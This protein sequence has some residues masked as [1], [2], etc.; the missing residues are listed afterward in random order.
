MKTPYEL[1]ISCSTGKDNSWARIIF[2][3]V[4]EHRV[5]QPAVFLN[6]NDYKY[7]YRKYLSSVS[8]PNRAFNALLNALFNAPF[9]TSQMRHSLTL[10]E[11][12][13]T[14]NPLTYATNPLTYQTIASV[15]VAGQW[16]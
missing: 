12:N 10:H 7:E 11:P 4:H 3:G 8:T 15:L 5:T 9:Y 2:L 1:A 6:T 14:S 16:L 13:S